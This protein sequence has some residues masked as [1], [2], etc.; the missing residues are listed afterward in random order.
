MKLPTVSV[1]LP[2][3][4]P[5]PGYQTGPLLNVVC[6]RYRSRAAIAVKANW[7]V[8]SVGAG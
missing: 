4:P 7:S 3:G 1:S 6:E 5:D 2:S 8:S